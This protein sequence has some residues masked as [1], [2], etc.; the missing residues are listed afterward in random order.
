MFRARVMNRRA[1]ALLV[2]AVLAAGLAFVGCGGGEA[3]PTPGATVTPTLTPTATATVTPTPAAAPA[4]AAEPADAEVILPDQPAE[5]YSLTD[6]SFQALQGAQAFFGELGG[7]IYRIEMPDDWNGRLVLWAHGFRSFAPDL[8]VDTHPLREYL[9]ENGYAWA[10]SSYSSNDFV[11]FEGAHETAALHDF[12]VQEFGQPDY[13]YISG[14]S[15]GGNAT[16]LS[17]ELFPSRYDGALAVC[18][19]VGLGTLDYFGHYLV[20]GAYTAGVTQEEFDAVES[21]GALVSERILPALEADPQA[22]ALFE[23]LVATLSGG[24]RPFR[25]QGFEAFYDFNFTFTGPQ[26]I[27]SGAFDNTDFV[28]PVGPASEVS[29]EDLNAQVVR[30]AGD[31]QVRNVD[32]NGSDLTGAVPVPL[33]MIHTTGDGFVPFSGEQIFRRAADAAGNGD[34]LVQRA[35]RA[36]GHCDF[37]GQEMISALE[38]L[39]NWVE[40]GTKPAGE[41]VLGPLQ[42]AGLDFTDPIREG[43]PGGL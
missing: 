36:I 13:T 22:R 28:Y 42:D 20:L 19:A 18:S 33:L 4:P 38:D 6:P 5:G 39:V 25:D 40:N 43:D 17:L 24:P 12:F 30:M 16:L 34:L 2:L 15:M 27:E 14:A 11:P 7:T 26:V 37:S 32:P 29:S 41:D 10:A 8:T 31:P 23:G 1:L 9:I 3:E 21:V 35:I